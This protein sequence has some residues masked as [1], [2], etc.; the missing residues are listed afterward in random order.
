MERLRS[1]GPAE[2]RGHGVSRGV[3]KRDIGMALLRPPR[4]LHFS[5]SLRITPSLHT[6]PSM[7]PRA[8]SWA[9]PQSN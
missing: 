6:N 4:V 5:H 9:I 7:T 8:I 1:S 2:A 3:R